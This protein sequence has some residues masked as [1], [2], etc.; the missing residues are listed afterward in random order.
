[1]LRIG[2]RGPVRDKQY[3]NSLLSKHHPLKESTA[4]F[5]GVEDRSKEEREKV[6]YMVADL[7]LKVSSHLK[8]TRVH[9]R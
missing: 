3:L 1:V 5:K 2:I 7:S 8:S 4:M 6:L 9:L